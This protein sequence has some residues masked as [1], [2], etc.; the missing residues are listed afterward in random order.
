MSE[1][2]DFDPGVW[3]GHDFSNARKAY[4][5]HVGR[6]YGDAVKTAVTSAD[7]LQESLATNSPAPLMI[8]C[9]VT[10]SMGTW[11]A[12]IFSKL[13]YLEL[14]GQEYLGKEME[15]AFGAIG[16]AFSDKYPLQVRPFG[17]GVDLA[18]ELKKLVVEG[19]GGGTNRESYELAALY[20]LHNVSIPKAINPIMI[21]IGDEGFYDMISKGDA[22]DSAKT[23]LQESRIESAN[24]FKDLMKKFSVYLIRKPYRNSVGDKRSP[25]DEIIHAQWARVLGEDRICMLPNAD[26]VVDVIFGILARETNRIDYFKDEIKNRQKPEQ[27]DTVM[28]SLATVHKLAAGNAPAPDVGS[29]SVMHKLTDGKKTKPLL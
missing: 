3:K 16:D 24:V 6:S 9:D 26:R 20:A 1:S 23:V 22:K 29:K 17:K 7:L 28:K 8:W 21:I 5:D 15:I 25:E 4:D 13:G 18:T 11:P 2:G 19:G 12:T 27:V 14:E 10:G